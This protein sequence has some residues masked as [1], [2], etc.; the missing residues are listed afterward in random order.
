MNNLLILAIVLLPALGA[1]VNGT[2]G[3]AIQK[4][5]GALANGLIAC[6][7]IG[8]AFLLTAFLFL[9]FVLGPGPNRLVLD[10]YPWIESGPLQVRFELS[11]DPLSTLMA[12]VVTGVGALIHV[13]SLGYMAHD[14]SP[15]RYFSYLN[16]FTFSMLML[17]L[18]NNLMLM[19]VGWEGV[20]LCSYLLIGFWYEDVAKARAGMKA[21]IV[22][23]IGDFGF[24]CGF[25]LLAWGL[26]GHF[27]GGSALNVINVNFD[28]LREHVHLLQAQTLWG[29]GLPTL[30]TL[31]FFFGATGKSAQIP[32]F[33][34]L[35][36]AMA[37]PTPVSAL[38]HAATMVTAGVYMIAR[39]NFLFVLAPATLAVVSGVGAL[40]ALFA[41]TVGFA[42]NDI[43]KVLAY[44]T[45]SQLGFMFVGVGVGAFTAGMFHLM[46]HAFFKACLFLGAG[47]VVHAMGGEQDIRRMGAL[48]KKLPRTY[49]T[50]L[51]AALAI[52][53]VP[54]LSGFFSKDEILW[55]T[56][57]HV[58]AAAPFWS[59]LV[60]PVALTAALCT[61]FYMFRLV[62]LTFFGETT[63]AAPEA[64]A[65]VH[66]SPATMTVPLVV[67]AALSIAGGFVGLPGLTGMPNYIEH[68]LGPVFEEGSKA[69]TFREPGHGAE[70]IVMGVSVLLAAVGIFIA[71]RI[72]GSGRFDGA[73]ALV[74]KIPA[75]HRWVLN[76]YYVDEAYETVFVKPFLGLCRALR[77]MDVRLV[78]GAVN[79]AGRSTRVFSRLDGW[80]DAHIV[81]GAVNRLAG[82]TTSLADKLRR[83]QTGRLQDA[84][85]LLAS[86]LFLLVAAML[87]V[88]HFA[89]GTGG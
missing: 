38:I 37:G 66:E 2:A 83:I 26:T 52:A 32:L 11:L 28:F 19:F 76:K 84:I 78:D 7:A 33:V 48:R 30:V 79:L 77:W 81:D 58:N 87:I 14:K 15:W 49:A 24:L 16:L 27:A 20:G 23:R 60:F 9:G 21:F 34:W 80:I 89:H 47:S 70:A 71:H 40:T 36:D 31:L 18:S 73:K 46:T 72:Y 54:G 51:I 25:F 17:V 6:S 56:F 74:Q 39:L 3:P 61:A 29:I 55:K 82:A 68:W 57:T 86:G 10:L 53:G 67:L 69:L 43:K 13:Y 62:F 5:F 8:L 65:H 50:F 45:I 44:S 41:A 1:A 42:Q 22:N 59:Y 4:R 85:Y 88:Q 75:L 35:P 12:L 63:R 64:L